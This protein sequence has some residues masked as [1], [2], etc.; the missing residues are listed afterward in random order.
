MDHLTE[1]DNLTKA[2]L[3]H[4]YDDGLMDYFIS[5]TFLIISLAG[6]FFFSN[7][8]LVWIANNMIRNREITTIVLITWIPLFLL[9]TFGARRIIELIRKNIYYKNRGFV[10]PLRLYGSWQ[11]NALASAI[12][13]IIIFFASR[14]LLNDSVSLEIFLRTL[15]SSTWIATAFIF[16]GLGKQMDLNRYKWVSVTGGLFSTL[17]IFIPVNFSISWM[18]NGIVWIIVLI[19]SGSLALRKSLISLREQDRE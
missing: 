7:F 13:V 2:T 18:L 19:I 12:F 4:D 17:L 9:Y 8:G 16:F 15:V 3:R 11:L 10:K 5:G 6:W 14:L 1:L